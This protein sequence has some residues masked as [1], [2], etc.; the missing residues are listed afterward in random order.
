MRIGVFCGS[1][2]GRDIYVDAA[3]NVGRTLAENGIELVY[4][5]ARVGAMGQLADAALEAGGT[6]IGVIP[7]GL[8]DRE[9]AHSGL[10]EL[11]VVET[12]HQRKACMSELSDAFMAL[13]GGSGT[14]EEVFEVWTWAQLGIHTKPVGLLDVAGYFR[15]LVEFID[16]SVGEGLLRAPYREMVMVDSDVDRLLQWYSNYLPPQYIWTEDAAR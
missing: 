16:H 12:L 5:G 13:P 8:V 11:R 4:G 6:V 1:S 15:H 9:V 7:Q 10:T 14:L 2:N 3:R